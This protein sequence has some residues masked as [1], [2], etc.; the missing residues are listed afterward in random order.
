MLGTHDQRTC[1]DEVLGPNDVVC[2]QWL[3]GLLRHYERRAAQA[4]SQ[5]ADR[6]TASSC[7][8]VAGYHCQ[9]GAPCSAAPRLSDPSR[10]ARRR[11]N[12][13]T[14]SMQRRW[15]ADGRPPLRGLSGQSYSWVISTILPYAE[16]RRFML[17]RSSGWWLTKP[18]R[19]A[20]TSKTCDSLWASAARLASLN[21]ALVGPLGVAECS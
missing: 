9:A 7:Q 19:T 20:Q 11:F 15:P 21:P 17:T 2:R 14:S 16:A 1:L 13:K 5:D 18:P 8:I 12:W 10:P 6:G 4:P 3:G